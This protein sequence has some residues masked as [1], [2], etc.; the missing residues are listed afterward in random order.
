MIILNWILNSLTLMLVANIVPGFTISSFFTALIASLILGLVNALIR[1][2]LLILTLPINFL[3]LGIFTFVINALML[4]LVSSI[5]KGFNIS[6]F[7][8]AFFAAI[9]LTLVSWALGF[10]LKPRA[11]N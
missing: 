4:L 11:L 1:P 2:I 10:F 9:L 6:S 8:S 7:S 3:T 5:V